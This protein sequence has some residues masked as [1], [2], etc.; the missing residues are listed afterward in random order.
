MILLLKMVI[1][2]FLVHHAWTREGVHL[3]HRIVATL[4][5]R[6]Q[7]LIGKMDDFLMGLEY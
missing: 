7:E 2:K 4:L 5:C 3:H 1:E 6:H